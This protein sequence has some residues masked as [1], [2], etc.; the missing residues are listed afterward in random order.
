M[1]PKRGRGRKRPDKNKREAAE[2]KECTYILQMNRH[3]ERV[4]A[5]IPLD[6]MTRTSIKSPQTAKEVVRE[7]T[8]RCG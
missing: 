1:L 5:Y 4:E 2:H 6:S 3:P 7:D 8:G